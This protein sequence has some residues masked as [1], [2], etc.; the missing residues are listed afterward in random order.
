MGQYLDTYIVASDEEGILIIDQHNAHERVLFERYKE[1]DQEKGWPAKLPL[2]PQVFDLSASQVIQFEE[3]RD[4][5]EEVGFVVENMGGRSYALKG[6]PEIF[7]EQE[8]GQLFLSL[9]EEMKEETVQ[10]KKG[11]LIAALACRSAVKAGQPLAFEKMNYLVEELFRTS[12]PSLCPHGRPIV[13]R[14]GKNQIEREIK[15]K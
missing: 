4:L 14:I 2:V 15:R 1:V 10:D 3:Y 5:L 12:N 11:K 6:Y 9:L 7:N 13:L 8:A